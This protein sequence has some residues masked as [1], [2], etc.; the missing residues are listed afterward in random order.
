MYW[1]HIIIKLSIPIICLINATY[2]HFKFS[3]KPFLKK[4]YENLRIILKRALIIWN[5][6]L[7]I[8]GITNIRFLISKQNIV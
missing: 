5:I 1:E 7:I 2:L 8:G 3:G 4:D 6:S